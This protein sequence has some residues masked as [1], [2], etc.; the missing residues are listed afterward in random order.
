MKKKSQAGQKEPKPKFKIQ[1]AELARDLLARIALHSI[2]V[3]KHLDA[4]H[5]YFPSTNVRLLE[6]YE[7]AEKKQESL[8]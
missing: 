3:Y 4:A 1:N 6:I 5:K 2:D 7:S 8:F